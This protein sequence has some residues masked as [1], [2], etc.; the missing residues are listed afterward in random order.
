[1]FS[2]DHD[3]PVRLALSLASVSLEVQARILGLLETRLDRAAA[4]QRR[5][6]AIR[7][8]H[9]MTGHIGVL[10]AAL[11]HYHLNTWPAVRHLPEPPPNE[12]PLR[13]AFF[14]ACLAASDGGLEIPGPRQIRRIVA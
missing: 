1:M 12:T 7:L 3:R 6:E 4:L 13:I 9:R 8:A 11:H 5:D 2:G 10:A 14:E